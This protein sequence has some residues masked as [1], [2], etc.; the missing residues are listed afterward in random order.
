MCP[1]QVSS[2]IESGLMAPV[3]LG[4]GEEWRVMEGGDLPQGWKVNLARTSYILVEDGA[5]ETIC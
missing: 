5:R 3:V 1:V 2:G 4:P